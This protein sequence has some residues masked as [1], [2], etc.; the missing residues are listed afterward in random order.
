MAFFAVKLHQ[1]NK[2]QEISYFRANTFGLDTD[3]K[4]LPLNYLIRAMLPF[5]LG[6]IVLFCIVV[7]LSAIARN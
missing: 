4:L 1:S 2:S 7:V 3:G 6:M 5:Q